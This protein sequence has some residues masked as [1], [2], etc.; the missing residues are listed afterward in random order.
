MG[1]GSALKKLIIGT[2]NQ[3]TIPCSGGDSCS[4]GS[5]GTANIPTKGSPGNEII[6]PFIAINNNSFNRY[7]PVNVSFSIPGYGESGT[8]NIPDYI[9]LDCP[10]D[11]DG[12]VPSGLKFVGVILHGNSNELCII[13][14]K[15]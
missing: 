11:E 10:F 7:D 9:A 15:V 13:G 12:M 14:R 2:P 3:P 8:C 5:I 4:G 1:F 6:Y